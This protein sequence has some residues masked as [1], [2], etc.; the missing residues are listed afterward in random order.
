[1]RESGEKKYRPNFFHGDS[2]KSDRCLGS[3]CLYQEEVE[4][5][6]H[7]LCESPS[8]QKHRL[9]YLDKICSMIWTVFVKCLVSFGYRRVVSANIRNCF[10]FEMFEGLLATSTGDL[11]DKTFQ[12]HLHHRPGSSNN[13]NK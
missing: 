11:H 8:L 1:M 3:D 13:N 4:P 9:L 10:D 12:L 5:V 6:P 2:I 7:L